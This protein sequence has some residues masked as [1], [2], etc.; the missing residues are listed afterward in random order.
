VVTADAEGPAVS[1][2]KLG[3]LGVEHPDEWALGLPAHAAVEVRGETS[4]A[5]FRRL[6]L[7]SLTTLNDAIGIELAKPSGETVLSVPARAL[8]GSSQEGPTFNLGFGET[9]RMLVDL[10]GLL[11]DALPG[12]YTARLSY[13]GRTRRTESAPFEIA[14]RLPTEDERLVLDALR[15]EGGGAGDW[16]S[17]TYRRRPR[18]APWLL[19]PPGHPLRYHLVL[20]ELLFGPEELSEVD[21]AVLDEVDSVARPEAEATRAELLAARGAAADF[22][23]QAARVRQQWPGLAWW[24]D[25]I[26]DGRSELAFLRGANAE[27]PG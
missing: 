22:Q 10:S 18:D 1:R 4:D 26:A 19:L 25:R 2:P 3:R 5:S 11:A 17:W 8:E 20:N 15:A 6:P 16:G 27:P 9:C 14:I 23:R 12:T 7:A 13:G 21:P 24:M